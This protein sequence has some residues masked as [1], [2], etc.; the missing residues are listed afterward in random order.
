MKF[1]LVSHGSYSKGILDSVQM[2]VGAQEDL[3]A[4]SLLPDEP[5]SV[6]AEALKNEISKTQGEILFFTDLFHGSPFNV[7]VSLMK[8]HDVHHI[9]GINLPLMVEA[10]MKRNAG[11]TINEVCENI[12][13]MAPET[14]VDVKKILDTEV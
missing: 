1:I 2:L 12:I 5:T 4:F 8:D 14:I 3:V 9:T 11:A 13:A 10:I 6:L 7:V